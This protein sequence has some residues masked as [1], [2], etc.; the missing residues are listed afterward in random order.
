ME[1]QNVVGLGVAISQGGNDADA[2]LT[3]CDLHRRAAGDRATGLQSDPATL[4]SAPRLAPPKRS[5]ERVDARKRSPICIEVR[6]FDPTVANRRPGVEAPLVSLTRI[7][8]S[9]G[10]R[11]P[12]TEDVQHEALLGRERSAP[13]VPHDLAGDLQVDLLQAFGVVARVT[14]QSQ[15]TAEISCDEYV[16]GSLRQPLKG[17]AAPTKLP[18]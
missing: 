8:S 12:T 15:A 6:A 5:R 7:V 17:S 13:A 16:F 9:A 10:A 14:P 3:C 2:E 18:S 1:E 4:R 11:S